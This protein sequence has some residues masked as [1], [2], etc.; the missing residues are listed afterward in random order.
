MI[1][2]DHVE[3]YPGTLADLAADLGDLRYDALAAFL[4]ALA[5]KLAHDAAGDAARGRA[6]LATALNAAVA[7]LVAAGEE[8]ARVW[9]IC[10]P[11][12]DESGER[13]VSAP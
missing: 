1:H 5:A 4:A 6:Q 3:R 2:R 13:G 9:A 12:M 11:Y 10:A 7:H 8:V